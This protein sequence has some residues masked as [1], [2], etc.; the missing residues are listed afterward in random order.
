MTDLIQVVL[1]EAGPDKKLAERGFC[2]ISPNMRFPDTLDGIIV[3]RI[4]ARALFSRRES[5]SVMLIPND[6]VG[7]Q[8]SDGTPGWHYNISYSTDFPG[9]PRPWS[10]QVLS[11]GGSVQKLS[12][13]LAMPIVGEIT[14]RV[15][16]P[17]SMDVGTSRQFTFGLAALDG[18][19]YPVD[20][21]TWEYVV[22]SEAGTEVIDITTTPTSE[23][24][25]VVTTADDFSDVT[26]TLNP[27][28]TVDLDPGTYEQALWMNPGTVNAYVWAAGSLQLN[29]VP[30]P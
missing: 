26:L 29:F 9:K 30:Q 14:G 22:R 27:A 25:I 12:D 20:S 6:A 21:A 19:P 16:W 8:R 23:G 4:A 1:D 13:L 3:G 5:P 11:T 2:L 18:T 15:D 24:K 17:V 7:P 28:A 10:F